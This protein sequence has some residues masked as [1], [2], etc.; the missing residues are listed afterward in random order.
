MLYKVLF[1]VPRFSDDSYND[2]DKKHG[3][4]QLQHSHRE[5]IPRDETLPPTCNLSLAEGS[6]IP[7]SCIAIFKSFQATLLPTT[8]SEEKLSAVKGGNIGRQKACYK[9]NWK[10]QKEQTLGNSATIT[11]TVQRGPDFIA[12]TCG[13]SISNQKNLLQYHHH[14]CHCCLLHI[15]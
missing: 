13:I 1:T 6:N 10:V 11:A 7:N 14:P 3:S 4:A 9:H 5:S 12:E 2:T 15:K 8:P